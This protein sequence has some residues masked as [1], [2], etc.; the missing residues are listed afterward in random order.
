MPKQVEFIVDDTALATVKDLTIN[1]NFEETAAALREMVAPYSSMIVSEDGIA[2]AKSD[3][4][5]LRKAADQINGYKIAIKKAYTAPVTAFEA[6]AKE[7]IAIIDTGVSNLDGQIKAFEEREKQEKIDTLR[8]FFDQ[9]AADV[10]EYINFKD[11][12]NPKWENKGYAVA[13][14]TGEITTAIGKTRADVA[15]IRT[16]DSPYISALLDEYAR[17]H[18]LGGVIA[19]S[20]S[21][22]ERDKREAE[23]KAAQEAA[24]RAAE[25]T[26]PA[27]APEPIIEPAPVA[28]VAVESAPVIRV[29]DFRVWA[30]DTQLA[31]LKAFL[32][33]NDIAYGR[34]PS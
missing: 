33:D 9:N 28:E 22:A 34:V 26:R 32:R 10:A 19:K 25:A 6:K 11:I 20:R 7:L 23:R 21:L 5:R 13:T 30:N 1:A 31:A 27:I 14:I 24:R 15:A 12:Y 8:D 18:D 2:D 29:I 3:R 17:T 16:L 4:A